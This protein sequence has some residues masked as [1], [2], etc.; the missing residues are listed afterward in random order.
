[1]SEDGILC[2]VLCHFLEAS[3]VSWTFYL[4]S[5]E[6]FIPTLALLIL[7]G[8][9]LSR[10]LIQTVKVTSVDLFKTFLRIAECHSHFQIGQ[11]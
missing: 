3:Y 6:C 11:N 1:M 5:A 9:Q 10:T 7:T 8:R 2:H 4:S